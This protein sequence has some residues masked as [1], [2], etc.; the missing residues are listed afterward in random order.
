[1]QAFEAHGVRVIEGSPGCVGKVPPW[2]KN[3]NST[4]E[5]LNLNLC[6]LRNIGIEVASQEKAGF[7]D[8]FWPMLE[9][10]IKARKLYGPDYAIA[11]ADGVH[12]GWAGHT[13]M[14][15]AFLKAMGLKGDLGTFIAD[16]KHDRM[17]V[18]KGHEL[19]SAHQ[20]EFVIRS[21]RYPF[22]ACLPTGEAASS[23]PICDG[24]D[25]ASD[26]TIHSAL[27]LIPFN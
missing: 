4:V 15:Y 1:D 19:I 11:G 26:K 17:K 25:S 13:I 3:P 27:T 2:T 10:G 18:S 16:L 23:Y 22:C 7:A 21:S 12:P 20:G 14:A 5:V 9:S 8:V 6:T 24:D